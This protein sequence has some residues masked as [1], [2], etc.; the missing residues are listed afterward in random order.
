MSGG[1]K[2][3]RFSARSLNL[4][5]A[6]LFA[7]KVELLDIS[8]GGACVKSPK[9]LQSGNTCMLKFED[10]EIADPINGTVMWERL[11][12]H[13]VD[14]SGEVVSSYVA[15][16]KF[17]KAFSQLT[18]NM[19]LM[20]ENLPFREYRLSSTRYKFHSKV[21]ASLDYHEQFRVKSLSLGG[22]LVESLN[23][24]PKDSEL[25]LLL[26]LPGQSRA[27]CFSSKVVSCVLLEG[28]IQ[29]SSRY[30]VGVEFIDMPA[31]DSARLK[32][33]IESLSVL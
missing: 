23:E 19:K 20:V 29:N 1:R 32:K 13:K 27:L 4:S 22:L 16:I 9:R 12:E 21:T 25:S 6:A 24:I 11:A 28:G 8:L 17:D 15:G 3:K 2:H 30:D 14:L 10:G 26:S 31:K 5:A 33:V 7:A 18:E